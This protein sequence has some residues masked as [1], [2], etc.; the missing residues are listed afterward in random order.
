MVFSPSISVSVCLSVVCLIH[1]HPHCF[2][3]NCNRMN[4]TTGAARPNP[5]GAYVY[6][7]IRIQRTVI[8]A[9]SAPLVKGR[10]RYAVNGNSFVYQD[11]PLLL[12]DYFNI[13]GIFKVTPFHTKPPSLATRPYVQMSTFVGGSGLKQNFTEIIFQNNEATLQTWHLDGYNFFVVG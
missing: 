5:Q 8:L 3:V 13:S 1:I 7:N 12:A 4:L 11:T 2:L 9:N 10:Q 6:K